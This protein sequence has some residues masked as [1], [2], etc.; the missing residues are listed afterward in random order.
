MHTSVLR[1]F[2]PS[3]VFLSQPSRTLA[4]PIEDGERVRT[5]SRTARWGPSRVAHTTA[6]RGLTAEQPGGY[7][8]DGDQPDAPVSDAPDAPHT[9]DADLAR[10]VD[11]L[12]GAVDQVARMDLDPYGTGE[13]ERLVA[14]LQRQLDRLTTC[15][16]RTVGVL[17]RRAVAVAGPGRES[18]AVQQVQRQIATELKLTASEAKR[19][20]DAGRTLVD[21]PELAAAADTGQLRPEQT[22]A[23]G[24]AMANLPAEH[25]DTVRDE[26]LVAAEVEDAVALGRRARRRL[27]E[28]DQQAA[29]DAEARRHARRRASVYQT[30][31]GMTG[32]HAEVSGLDAETVWTAIDAFRTPDGPREPAR[33]PEQRTADALVAA[34]RASLDLG[35]AATDRKVRPHLIVTVTDTDLTERSGNVELPWSGPHPTGS[36]ARVAGDA[37]LH[38]IGTDSAGLPISLSRATDQ[39]TAGLYLALAHRDGGCRHPGCDAPAS[40]CDIAHATARRHGGPVTI[41][42]TLLLCRRHHRRLDLGSWTIHIDGWQ[43]TFT[44]PTGHTLAA[45]HPDRAPPDDPDPHPPDTS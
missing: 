19:A 43:A 37:T 17:R 30:P 6:V 7:D 11:R 1:I 12:A 45:R 25:A 24:R 26:L 34:L 16:D 27:A 42:N 18:R 8:R 31:D 21:R 2:A 36:V 14:G 29:C 9:V 15:R 22:V 28:L 13:V 33:S 10:L 35:A 20:S 32:L 44:D 23:I 3:E 5:A 40:W 41:D 4:V 38:V 39:P